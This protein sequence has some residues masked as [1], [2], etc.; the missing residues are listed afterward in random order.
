MSKKDIKHGILYL[1]QP[2]KYHGTNIYKIGASGKSNFERIRSY[3]KDSTCILT[4]GCKYPFRIEEK[5]LEEYNQKFR[6]AKGK[7][8]FEGNVLEMR[9]IFNKHTAGKYIDAIDIENVQTNNIIKN[10]TIKKDKTNK[11]DKNNDTIISSFQ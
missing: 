11:I 1:I 9:D 10:K 8:Y 6:L 5:I 3:S 7:E 4:I 2:K